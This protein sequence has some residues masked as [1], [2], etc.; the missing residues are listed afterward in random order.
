MQNASFQEKFIARLCVVFF[1]FGALF[2]FSMMYYLR[3]LMEEK[4]SDKSILIFANILAV[5]T[6]VRETLRPA[7]YD[8]LNKDEFLIEAMSTSY[9]TRMIS[10]DLNTAKDQYRYRRVALDSR[11]PNYAANELEQSLIHYFQ[12]NPEYKIYNKFQTIN[13]EDVFLAARPV[14]FEERCLSCHGDPVSAPA[15][16]LERYGG[17]RGFGRSVGE[18][19]GL[20]MLIMPVEQDR[21]A[22]HKASVLF[23]L[24]LG[25]GALTIL[26]VNH[27]FFDRIVGQNLSRM[28]SLLRLRFPSEAGQTLDR[29]DEDIEG[30]LK[31]MERFADHL[32]AAK[33]QLAQHAA[34]L[35][36]RVEE[37]T[38]DLTRLAN[39]HRT[40]VELFVALLDGLNQHTGKAGL[41]STSLELIARRFAADQAV[42]VC[43]LSSTEYHSWPRSSDMPGL[44]AD[45]HRLVTDNLTYFDQTAWFIPVQTSETTR[46]LLCLY[47]KEPPLVGPRTEELTLA[48]GRQLGV[49]LDNIEALDNLLHQNSLLDSIFEGISDPLLLLDTD[50]HPM[51]A[52]SSAR[53]L[54]EQPSVGGEVFGLEQLSSSVRRAAEVL[55]LPDGRSFSVNM[56]ALT[57]RRE[58]GGHIVYLRETTEELRMLERAQRQEKLAAVGKLAAGLAHE[59]NNPLGVILCHAELLRET[60]ASDLNKADLDMI[61]RHTEQAQKVLRD[62]L[63][64]SRPKSGDPGVCDLDEVLNWMATVFGPRLRSLRV[65]LEMELSSVALGA[66]LPPI[67]ADRDVLEQ[68]F[69]NIL[70]NALDALESVG[71]E[72]GGGRISVRTWREGYEI[73]ARIADSGPGI[74]HDHLSRIFD[75]FFTTKEV[76]RGTGLGLSVVFGLV[77]DLGGR[78]EMRNVPDDEGGAEFVLVLPVAVEAQ[79]NLTS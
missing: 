37:R 74:P 54:L 25:C 15:V 35:E 67:R 77:R 64:F 39:D 57:K 55:H 68:I 48:V 16:L 61:I 6:Y 46:G 21:D 73:I 70:I 2:W 71:G 26:G 50:G 53:R 32:H 60:T 4:V 22:I 76:G 59:I 17:S 33:T 10:S 5:Q 51:L 45:W 43:V 42:Y 36:E 38:V 8:I 58:R 69:T 34:T 18:V 24:V 65:T 75:P 79:E 44:P 19:A 7:M 63:D 66:A 13:D 12:R 31:S 47:W 41:L 3:V 56:Y 1:C 72:F 11:N 28:S 27:F 52:N 14:V 9:V 23:I 49:A 40:D 29:R 78:I 20:D 30:M 62:L